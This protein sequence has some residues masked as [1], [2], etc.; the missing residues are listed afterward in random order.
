ML[1][2]PQ[3]MVCRDEVLLTLNQL[4]IM[5]HTSPCILYK[6]ILDNHIYVNIWLLL[7]VLK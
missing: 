3:C 7:H 6:Y 5:I 4:A 2:I 1:A